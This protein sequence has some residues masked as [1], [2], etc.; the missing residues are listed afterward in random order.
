MKGT[1]IEEYLSGDIYELG[2]NGG[3][4]PRTF[5][6]VDR[7]LQLLCHTNIHEA[8]FTQD[9]HQTCVQVLVGLLSLA[10]GLV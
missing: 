1:K 10:V 9:L 5:W 2:L 6:L 8:L 3:I 7:P 4:E